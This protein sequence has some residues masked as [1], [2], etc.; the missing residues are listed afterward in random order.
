MNLV[1]YSQNGGIEVVVDAETGESY[2]SI[3]AIARMTDKKGS[4]IRDYINSIALPLKKAQILTPNSLRSVRLL[5]E[6]QILE[7]VA[8]Y[9]PSLLVAFSKAGLRFYLHQLAGYEITVKPKEQQ[10]SSSSRLR[11]MIELAT[12]I[13]FLTDPKVKDA[14]NC[15][16]VREIE[17]MKGTK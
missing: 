14:L 13:Q 8:K 17:R 11:K 6:N 1:P 10:D 7:V 15:A 2:A 9:K 16:L 5:N 4:A 3:N 12:E